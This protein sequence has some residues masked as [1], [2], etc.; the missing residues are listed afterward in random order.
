M[1]GLEKVDLVHYVTDP[2]VIS[3]VPR[4]ICERHGIFPIGEVREKFQIASAGMVNDEILSELKFITGRDVEV[5]LSTEEQIANAIDACYEKSKSVKAL[6]FLKYELKDNSKDASLD[7]VDENSSPSIDL[8]DSIISLGIGRGSSDIHIEPFEK[9]SRIRYRVDGVLSEEMRIPSRIHAIVVSRVK[10]LCK[11]D[12]SEKRLPQDGKFRFRYKEE[13]YDLRVSTLPASHGENMVIRILYRNSSVSSLE[14]LG[15]D[16]AGINML[17]QAVKNP[18]GIILLT[19][20]T[21]SGKST[22]LY[23][24]LSQIDKVRNNIVTIED[25]V[26][27]SMD[28]ITQVN[29]NSKINLTFA[30]GLRSILRQDPDVIL[31]GE[32]RDEETAHIAVR[33]AITGHLVLSTLHT[34]DAPSCIS[35]LMDMNIPPYLIEDA[36]RV[37]VAQRLVRKICKQCREKYIPSREELNMAGIKEN[38]QLYRGRGCSVCNNTGYKGR[39]VIYHVLNM[40]RATISRIK[41][42]HEAASHDETGMKELRNSC[43]SLM[44]KGVTSMGE[45]M[46]VVYGK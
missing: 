26:E 12:I 1:G 25:P 23:T 42:N 43:I 4:E 27:F 29:V 17:Q 24:L 34:N 38:V 33:A 18:N 36:L 44:M 8:T 6:E 2:T 19:G 13:D 28:G 15:F 3:K 30:E 7:S 40:D 35:R 32:I 37:V 9:F 10:V 11:L 5:F 16:G 22:T 46:R 39:T 21:G 41:N 31:I 14:A 45:F 20:P